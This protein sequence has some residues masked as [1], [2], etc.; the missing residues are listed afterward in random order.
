ML[1]ASVALSLG[2]EHSRCSVNLGSMNSFNPCLFIQQMFSEPLHVP[3]TVLGTRVWNFCHLALSLGSQGE[4]TMSPVSLQ[5]KVMSREGQAFAG[6]Q[7]E[8]Q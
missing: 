4:G 7:P 8:H 3:G 5:E 2:L 1:L 6:G